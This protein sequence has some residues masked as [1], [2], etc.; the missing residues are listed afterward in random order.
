MMSLVRQIA[1]RKEIGRGCPTALQLTDSVVTNMNV[2]KH[3]PRLRSFNAL[4]FDG[5]TGFG[6]S[7]ILTAPVANNA[8]PGDQWDSLPNVDF[9]ALEGIIPASDG[10]GIGCRSHVGRSSP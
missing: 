6:M 4:R 8:Q 2:Y 10:N 1:M 7:R 3:N 9:Y 5:L